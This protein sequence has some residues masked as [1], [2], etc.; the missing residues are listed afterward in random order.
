MSHGNPSFELVG[1]RI[2]VQG[3]VTP[4]VAGQQVKVS[5]YREGHKVGVKT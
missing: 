1:G 3:I 2:A 5:F 4:Y